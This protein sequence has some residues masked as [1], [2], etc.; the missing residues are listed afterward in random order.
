[1]IT[2]AQPWDNLKFDLA[3][4]TE[5]RNKFFGTLTNTYNFF[6]L[7][8]NLDGFD[9]SKATID[10]TNLTELDRW[11]LSKLMHLIAEVD[12]S[13]ETYEPTKAGRAIQ[14]FVCDHLSNWY[15]RLS[16][17]RFWNPEAKELGL[18]ADKKAA[19]QTLYTSLETVAQ[20]M[21]P[22]AP[23]YGEW[24]YKNLTQKES[25]HLTDFARV[26][27]AWRNEN[28]EAS[29][30]LAQRICSLVHSIRKV[31]KLKVRQP[32]AQVL[33]P[34]L[35]E[36][37]REQIRRVEDLIKSEVNVKQV[38]YLNDASGV[39]SKRV[40]PNFKALG[41]KF[42]KNM[43]S[44]AELITGMSSDDLLQ[45]ETQGMVKLQGFE[46]GLDDIEVLTEDMPGYL[47]A[48]EGGLTIALD[49]T[50]SPELIREGMA[51]EFVNRVQNLRKDLGFEVVDKIH[52]SIQENSGE[53]KESLIEFKGY[54]SQEVQALSIDWV[55]EI[56][57]DY[58]EVSI[59]DVNLNVR[60]TVA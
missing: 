31:H 59:D 45:V 11:I 36:N 6:A 49:H 56:G 12:E 29:M 3:G 38:N 57:D 30:E 44:V 54:I 2:N 48:S 39:L 60:L 41:P 32:L 4:I 1:M 18:S 58:S 43:K 27:P 16:R 35:Q 50:L 20:L 55:K 40:K 5:V 14:D 21:S 37:V 9:G 22:I 28:L 34:V 23:F 15:V 25:I 42:G 8:A 51:R 53:W 10:E 26:N 46:I 33:V 13:F 17:R 19:Y 47:T 7:Y 52:I 24:L